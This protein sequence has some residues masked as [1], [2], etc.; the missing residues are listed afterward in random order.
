MLQNSVNAHEFFEFWVSREISGSYEHYAHALCVTFNIRLRSGRN[1]GG[2][3][4]AI[5]LNGLERLQNSVNA[6]I[7]RVFRG[8]FRSYRLCAIMR[9]IR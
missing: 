3:A 1:S 4:L 6:R 5:A 2:P 9:N 7:I 8:K